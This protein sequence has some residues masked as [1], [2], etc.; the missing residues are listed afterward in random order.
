MAVVVKFLAL[1][2]A[3]EASVFTIM[4]GNFTLGHTVSLFESTKEDFQYL[5]LTFLLLG[6]LDS[7]LM[8]AT[9]WFQV[10]AGETSGEMV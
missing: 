4:M 7:I 6:V 5:F 8:W 1:L 2:Y 9:R 10:R 3:A